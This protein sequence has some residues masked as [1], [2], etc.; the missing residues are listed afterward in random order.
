M[1]D[2][3]EEKEKYI[4]STSPEPVSFKGTENI[5]NQMNNCVCRIYNNGNGTGFFTKI[6]FKS[7]LLPVLITNNHILNQND[8]KNNETIILDLNNDKILKKLKIDN[9]R[10]RYTNEKL[11]ITIIEIKENEDKLNNEYLK[12]DDNIINYFKSNENEDPNYL[13]DIYSN[14]SIYIINYPKDKDIVVSYGKSPL[15]NESEIKHYCSTEPG[16]SGSP[17][18]LINNQKLIGI[19]Y[20]NSKNFDFNLGTLLIYSIIEF[21][22]INNNLLIINKE[23]DIIENTEINNCIIGEFDIKEDNQYIRIINSYEQS[24]REIKFHKY[25]KENENEKEII[26]N[27]EIRINNK[28]IPF[29]YF[30][31]FNK[32][33]KYIIKF[34]FKQNITK[35]S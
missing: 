20:G 29:S 24:N 31:N 32:K 28:I 35:L 4:N 11:D 12:L 17:I 21:Q 15:L 22:K 34:I 18:L 16:S 19:H 14:E 7:K 33:S 30:Y 23:G 6:P 8:I 5:L 1:E 9:N 13:N 25:E 26:E 10:L 27:C 2:S 3:K